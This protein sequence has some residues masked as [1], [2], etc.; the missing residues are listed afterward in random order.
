M[1][2]PEDLPVELAPALRAAAERLMAECAPPRRDWGRP[3][4]SHRVGCFLCHQHHG[5]FTWH[6]LI[7]DDDTSL[8]PIHPSCHRRLHRKAS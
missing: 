7:P 6:H 4:E 5:R 8:V 1:T 2:K 3:R